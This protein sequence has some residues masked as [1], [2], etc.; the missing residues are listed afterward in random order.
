MP[1]SM[2]LKGSVAYS[3]AVK[4]TLCAKHEKVFVNLHGSSWEYPYYTIAWT[5]SP[6]GQISL[7]E[8][9]GK[10]LMDS[11]KT[12]R[13]YLNPVATSEV[14][15]Q[16]VHFQADPRGIKVTY[17]SSP[18]GEPLERWEVLV[19]ASGKTEGYTPDRFV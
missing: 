19:D 7:R 8:A 2:H 9:F 12:A 3:D 18:P 16:S 14:F 13:L 10:T 11:T 6:S 15:F 17:F 5:K 1:S 4:K